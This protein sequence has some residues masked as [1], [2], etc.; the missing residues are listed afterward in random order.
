[1]F[2]AREH[3]LDRGHADICM[4]ASSSH[5]HMQVHACA[6]TYAP[7][8]MHTL[9]HRPTRTHSPSDPFYLQ[10]SLRVWKSL[11]HGFLSG[12]GIGSVVLE[13]AFHPSLGFR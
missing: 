8:H 11:S 10:G 4:R 2:H 6:H 9:P 3:G 12:T 7:T 5:R 1:M 13:K